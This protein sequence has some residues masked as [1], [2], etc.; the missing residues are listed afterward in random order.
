MRAALCFRLPV[1]TCYSMNVTRLISLSVVSPFRTLL[2]ADCRS[3]VMPSAM[4]TFLTSEAGRFS[5]IISRI[6]S[7]RSRNSV[8]AFLPRYPVKC[9]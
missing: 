8:M 4:A 1:D 5:R 9:K 3:V 7:D 6:L 2:T